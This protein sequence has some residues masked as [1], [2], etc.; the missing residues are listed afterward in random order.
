MIALLE[1]GSELDQFSSN[2]GSSQGNT[3]VSEKQVDIKGSECDLSWSLFQRSAPLGASS[4]FS[5]S[6]PLGGS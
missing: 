1:G 5:Q 4:W 6:I 3:A 2:L